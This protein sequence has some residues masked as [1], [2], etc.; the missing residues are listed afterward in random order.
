[1]QL[2]NNLRIFFGGGVDQEVQGDVT[3]TFR[4]LQFKSKQEMRKKRRHRG[5]TEKGSTAKYR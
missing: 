2:Q 3:S 1:M 5:T 4:Q